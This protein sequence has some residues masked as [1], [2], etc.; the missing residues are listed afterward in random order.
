MFSRKHK[1]RPVTGVAKSSKLFSEVF[2]TTGIH[3]TCS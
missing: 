1:P 3:T 2:R